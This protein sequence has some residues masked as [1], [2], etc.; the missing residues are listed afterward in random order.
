VDLVAS[1]APLQAGQLV[2][3]EEPVGGA[4]R[5]QRIVNRAEITAAE[6]AVP[7]LGPDG[8]NAVRQPSA[9]G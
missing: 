6:S 2:S 1:E 4:A 5:T 8:G 3:V 7:G 9:G